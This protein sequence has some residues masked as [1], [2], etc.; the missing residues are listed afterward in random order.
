M[1]PSHCLCFSHLQDEYINV[2]HAET[3]VQR[4][5][6]QCSFHNDCHS[7]FCLPLPCLMS[8]TKPKMAVVSPG[9]AFVYTRPHSHPHSQMQIRYPE[10]QPPLRGSK[11]EILFRK[12]SPNEDNLIHRLLYRKPRD[13]GDANV[14]GWTLKSII[15]NRNMSSSL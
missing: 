4:T 12:A 5:Y 8:T 3:W 13:T 1:A 10:G 9:V 15:K 7:C 11:M 6:F 14:A 2:R